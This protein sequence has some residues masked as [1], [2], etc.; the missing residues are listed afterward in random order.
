MVQAGAGT[1]EELR[2]LAARLRAYREREQ[3]LWARTIK[4]TL[5]RRRGGPDAEASRRRLLAVAGATG[6]V[7]LALLGLA[8]GNPAVVL[9]VL[10]AVAA[11]VY[12]ARREA[13]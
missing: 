12:L 9:V 10:A 8:S 5:S 11:V 7:I 2:A 6:S 3:E 4:P 1:P 13:R